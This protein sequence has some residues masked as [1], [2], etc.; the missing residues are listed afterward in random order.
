M[1]IH[2]QSLKEP[3]SACLEPSW[4]EVLGQRAALGPDGIELQTPGGRL[5]TLMYNLGQIL[6][7]LRDVREPAQKNKSVLFSLCKGEDDHSAPP[8]VPACR[9]IHPDQME[10][11][12]IA[13]SAILQ[14]SNTCSDLASIP[15]HPAAVQQLQ[16]RPGQAVPEQRGDQGMVHVHFLALDICTDGTLSLDLTTVEPPN[17]FYSFWA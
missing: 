11:A 12:Q 8:L 7:G 13:Q 9:V 14:L 10:Q 1:D 6:F 15:A 2:C 16:S 17:D 4:A 5:K 3:E